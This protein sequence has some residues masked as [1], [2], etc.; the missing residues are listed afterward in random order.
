MDSSCQWDEWFS[1]NIQPHLWGLQPGEY[2][3]NSESKQNFKINEACNMYNENKNQLFM[4]FTHE[5]PYALH[6]ASCTY[7]ISEISSRTL[8]IITQ[9]KFQAFFQVPSIPINLTCVLRCISCVRLCD[10][11]DCGPPGS[12][13]LS[14]KHTHGLIYQEYLEHLLFFREL[15]AVT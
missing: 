8:W 9:S 5:S 15:I 12:S 7:N 4:F 2:V 1:L 6:L 14:T 13:V 3:T 10:P 11:M